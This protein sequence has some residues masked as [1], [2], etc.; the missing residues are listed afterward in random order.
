MQPV[1]PVLHG[2]LLRGDFGLGFAAHLVHLFRLA[3]LLGLGEG[4][5]ARALLALARV[6]VVLPPPTKTK[7]NK[8]EKIRIVSDRKQ[9]VME[10]ASWTTQL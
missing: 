8:L 5:A 1:V 2:E 4:E 9:G 6:R 10:S 3:V 7:N